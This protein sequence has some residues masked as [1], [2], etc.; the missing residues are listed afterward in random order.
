M[1]GK[2]ERDK[3]RLVGLRRS[4]GHVAPPAQSGIA[5]M[6]DAARPATYPTLAARFETLWDSAAT[7]PDVFA[8]LDDHPGASSYDRLDVLLVDR[9]RRVR[10]GLPCPVEAYLRAC[11]DVAADQALKM[12]LV[13]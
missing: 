5:A 6:T 8:F 13:Y 4:A 12:E 3:H 10:S 11:P 9:R 7:P 1:V 2:V